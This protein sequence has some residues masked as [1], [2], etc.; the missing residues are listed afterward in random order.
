[1]YGPIV[2]TAGSRNSIFPLADSGNGFARTVA[3]ELQRHAATIAATIF[4][5]NLERI[6][7]LALCGAAA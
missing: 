6:N 5:A 3:T 1:M 7:F 4:L 2:A